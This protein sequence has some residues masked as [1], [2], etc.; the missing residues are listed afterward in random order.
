MRSGSDVGGRFEETVRLALRCQACR[1]HDRWHSLRFRRVGVPVSAS[2]RFIQSMSH[3]DRCSGMK[4]HI[5]SSHKIIA[6]RTKAGLEIDSIL[7]NRKKAGPWPTLT[8][9]SALRA[10][11]DSPSRYAGGEANSLWRC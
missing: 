10:L 5:T 3:R 8:D 1:Y 11:G 6:E 9:S 7:E 4:V 2:F